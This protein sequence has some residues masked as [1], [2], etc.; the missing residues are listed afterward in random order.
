MS[1]PFSHIKCL[2]KYEDL[3]GEIVEQSMTLEQRKDEIKFLVY[4]CSDVINIKRIYQLSA[5][6]KMNK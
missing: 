4:N 5:L 3:L 1:L 6:L 2:N